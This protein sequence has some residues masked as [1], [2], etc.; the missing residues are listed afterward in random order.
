VS[1]NLR[2]RLLEASGP[3]ARLRVLEAELER[4]LGA[5]KELHSAVRY[6]LGEF[7]R[8]PARDRDPE[9]HIWHVGTYD[10]WVPK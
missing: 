8:D 5:P 7:G 9:G 3:A 1:G 4:R 6:A 2:D 10:P